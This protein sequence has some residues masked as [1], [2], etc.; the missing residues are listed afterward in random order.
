MKGNREQNS[1]RKNE[2]V[3]NNIRVLKRGSVKRER[4][5]PAI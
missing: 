1:E 2:S 5:A 4:E 3:E